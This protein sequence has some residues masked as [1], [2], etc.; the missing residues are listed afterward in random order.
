[1]GVMKLWTSHT[2]K[3]IVRCLAITTPMIAS[4]LVISWIVY[5]NLVQG[6]CLSVELC[7][8]TDV[9]GA[10]S[11]NYFYIDFPA[12]R[13]ALISS[14][15]STLSFTLIGYLMTITAYNT[16]ASLLRASASGVH[17]ELPSPYQL[18]ILLRVLN[19]ELMVLWTLA[20]S[21]IKRVFW[22]RDETGNAR[23]PHVLRTGV[24]VFLAAIIAGFVNIATQ[25]AA[26]EVNYVQSSRPVCRCI[27][28][29]RC[30]ITRV[31]AS[32]E[33]LLHHASV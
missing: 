8:G 7:P 22:H 20:W 29:H 6:K 30:R 21:K 9:L 18:S 23:P 4:S 2:R 10:A 27:L 19:A 15:S 11:A 1:M 26:M 32:A 13:L 28:S 33:P 25:I 17:E 31:G 3:I 5:A 12:A 24:L 14:A 16:T